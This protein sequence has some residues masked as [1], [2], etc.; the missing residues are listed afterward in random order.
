MQV[1][2]LLNGIWHYFAR[3]VVPPPPDFSAQSPGSPSSV[4]SVSSSLSAA[5]NRED[6]PMP[7]SPRGPTTRRR[8]QQVPLRSAGGAAAAKK[9][10]RDGEAPAAHTIEAGKCTLLGVS[11]GEVSVEKHRCVLTVSVIVL[12]CPSAA[13]WFAIEHRWCLPSLMSQTDARA[14]STRHR[15][16]AAQQ[17][18]SARSQV[19]ARGIDRS[20]PQAS[21]R[22]W[23]I[24]LPQPRKAVGKGACGRADR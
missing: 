9:R 12:A 6:A 21:S 8:A 11:A 4:I 22:E 3:P 2:S 16:C 15:G 1:T 13:E 19:D 10:G 20:L 7:S 23:Q 24:S 5:S 18:R 17:A 14:R